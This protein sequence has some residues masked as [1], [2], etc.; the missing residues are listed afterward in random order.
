MTPD[1]VSAASMALCCPEDATEE[2]KVQLQRFIDGG[3]N[4]WGL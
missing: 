2:E 4:L 1:E 3:G